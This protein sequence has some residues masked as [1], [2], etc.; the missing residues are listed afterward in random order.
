[1]G[2]FTIRKKNLICY[3][4]YDSAVVC[5]SRNNSNKNKDDEIDVIAS[6]VS[7]LQFY[8]IDHAM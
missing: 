7:L 5:Y 1:M 6:V 4:T 2:N 3:D 8:C